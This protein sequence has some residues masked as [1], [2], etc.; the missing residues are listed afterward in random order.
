MDSGFSGEKFCI[1]TERQ[2]AAHT[3]GIDTMADHDVQERGVV[4]SSYGHFDESSRMEVGY[5][6]LMHVLVP[7]GVELK[8]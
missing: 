4:V 3:L 6:A 7:S 8:P 5:D 2:V 1:S